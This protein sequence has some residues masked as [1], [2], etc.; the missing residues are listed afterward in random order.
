ME[1]ADTRSPANLYGQLTRLS[2]QHD[3]TFLLFGFDAISRTPASFAESRLLRAIVMPVDVPPALMR[4]SALSLDRWAN[5]GLRLVSVDRYYPGSRVPTV[6]SDNFDGAYQAVSHLLLIGRQ[7]VIAVSMD[8]T[9]TSSV[10]ARLE[11]YRWAFKYAGLPAHPEWEYTTFLRDQD[12]FLA[13]VDRVRPDGLFAL[14][15]SIDMR[16]MQLLRST[17]RSIPDD[18]VVV[19]FDDVPAAALLDV[20]LPTVRQD[21][22]R[23]GMEAARLL[24]EATPPKGGQAT[25]VRIKIPVEL[26]VRD[27][28][29][30]PAAA[31]EPTSS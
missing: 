18:V 4:E 19:G 9:N 5:S 13:F 10:T 30:R 23:M 28:T 20:P 27:S 11:G 6:T 25:P 2:F 14:N 7:R 15:D 16:C 31:A 1:C 3:R 12:D 29:A 24:L 22:Q 26:I 8:N 21:G 17:G